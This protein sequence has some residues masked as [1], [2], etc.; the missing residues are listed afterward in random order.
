VKL[1]VNFHFWYVVIWGTT[2]FLYSFGWSRLNA[3]LSPDLLIFFF[4]TILIS[5][6]LAVLHE[7]RAPR[8]PPQQFVSRNRS[9]FVRWLFT[10]AIALGFIADFA[11]QRKIPLVSG[12]YAGYDVTQDVQATVGIPG[13]HVAVI[14]FAIFYSLVLADRYGDTRDRSFILQFVVI[15]AFLLLNN[16]RGYLAF[17][18]AG[19]LMITIAYRSRRAKPRRTRTIVTGLAVAY[20]LILGIGIFGNIRT[21]LSWSDS[22]YITRIGLYGDTF[23]AFL[24]DQIKWFY[25]YITSPLANLNYNLTYFASDGSLSS[26]LVS[27][28]PDMFG[29]YVVAN[30]LDVGYQ[31]TYLNATTGYMVPFGLGGG[32][33]AMYLNYAIQIVVLEVGAALMRHLNVAYILYCAAGSIVIVVFV[34]YNSYS[35]SATCFL[36][37]LAILTGIVRYAKLKWRSRVQTGIGPMPRQALVGVD[38]FDGGARHG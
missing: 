30:N 5:A 13:V 7:L 31:V 26:S 37:P 18:I 36:L 27:F 4:V 23:P 2:L 29:K 35:N 24:D 12:G 20:L 34:F 14:V 8:R 10:F 25:T 22:T 11:Y 28:L 3:P 19:A 9:V 1:A 16:S 38:A 15:Q 21:G 6:I 32:I 33:G 17:C